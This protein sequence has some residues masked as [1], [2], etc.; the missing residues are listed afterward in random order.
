[1]LER[2]INGSF[3]LGTEYHEDLDYAQFA[4]K[5]PVSERACTSE[6]VWLTQ[7][8]LLGTEKDMD[9]IVD[10]IAKVLGHRF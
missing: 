7:N 9:D 1:M 6:A 3:P 10:A 5:C 4:E 2:F 8:L